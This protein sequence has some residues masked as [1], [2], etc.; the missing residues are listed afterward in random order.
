[1]LSSST[2]IADLLLEGSEGYQGLDVRWSGKYFVLAHNNREKLTYQL[3]R[4]A[5]EIGLDRTP[6]VDSPGMSDMQ[7]RERRN[8]V[9]TW[10]L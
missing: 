3:C 5:V 2:L 7:K 10:M 8:S 4:I 6:I 9:R 1:V